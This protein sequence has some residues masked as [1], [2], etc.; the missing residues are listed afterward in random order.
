MVDCLMY[1]G[2]NTGKKVQAMQIIKHTFE[3]IHLMTGKN[4]IQVPF[5]TLS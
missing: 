3:I 2:R 1:K 4:P 5:P